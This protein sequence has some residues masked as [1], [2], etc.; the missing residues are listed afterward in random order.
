MHDLILRR[1][2][3]VKGQKL[4]SIWSSEEWNY[5]QY[6]LGIFSPHLYAFLAPSCDKQETMVWATP[7]YS[8]YGFFDFC[9]MSSYRVTG[10]VERSDLYMRVLVEYYENKLIIHLDH[11]WNST[12]WYIMIVLDGLYKVGS[13]PAWQ[14]LELGVFVFSNFYQKT[15]KN[16]RQIVPLFLYDSLNDENRK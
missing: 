10:V 12:E 2:Y 15:W 5:Y 16:L 4:S 14:N 1:V 6:M 3:H 13:L 8:I 9:H 11:I 7:L